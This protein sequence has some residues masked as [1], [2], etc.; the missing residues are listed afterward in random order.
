MRKVL[1]VLGLLLVGQAGS[2]W[3]DDANDNQACPNGTYLK[4]IGTATTTTGAVNLGTTGHLIRASRIACGGTACVSTVYDTDNNPGD[5]SD[6]DI[7]DEPGSPANTAT[8]TYYN[9]P[10]TVAQG[11]TVHNDANVNGVLFYECRR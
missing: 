3:A 4:V 1:I 7:V 6:D 8:W 9:P 5:N 2:A 11:L 10:L